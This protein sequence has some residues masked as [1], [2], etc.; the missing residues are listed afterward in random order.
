MKNRHNFIKFP[1]AAALGA[2]MSLTVSP[3]FARQAQS[4]NGSHASTLALSKG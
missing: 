2:A 4:R 3:S 1:L